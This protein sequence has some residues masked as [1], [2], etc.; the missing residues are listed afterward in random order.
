MVERTL[1][2]TFALRK[3]Y[4]YGTQFK[5]LE[6]RAHAKRV[7]D[8]DEDL[9]ESAGRILGS[10]EDMRMNLDYSH[11]EGAAI[12]L[13]ESSRAMA[14]VEAESSRLQALYPYVAEMKDEL[15][16][17]ASKA[18]R[19]LNAGFADPLTG[20]VLEPRNPLVAGQ[21]YDLLIDVGP[22]WSKV[23]SLVIGNEI[24]PEAALPPDEDGYAIHVVFIS[25]DTEPK[26]FS[27]WIWI[28]RR[29]GRS[30]PYNFISK[31]KAT[32]CG[33]IAFR[34]KAPALAG[35][36]DTTQLHGRLCLYYENNL[37][38]SAR[39]QA[40]VAR[41][42]DVRLE[43]DNVVDVDYVLSGTVQNLERLATRTL[44]FSSK[45]QPREHPIALNLTLNDD[46]KAHRILVRELDE[47][48]T[49]AP[50]SDSPVGW[51]PFD[52]SAA[53]DALNKAREDLKSCFYERDNNGNVVKDQSGEPKIWVNKNGRGK[54]R[55]Q[56]KWD[57]LILAELGSSLFN[58]AF[59]N[60]IPEGKWAT[61]AKWMRALQ[62][63]LERKSIIQVARTGPANYVFP[64]GLVY[65]YPLWGARKDYKFCRVINAEWAEDGLR[66]KEP[67]DACPYRNEDYH[68]KDVICPYGF[69]GLNHIIEQPVSALRQLPDGSYVHQDATDK[70]IMLGDNLDL[71]VV[72]THDVAK[73]DLDSHLMRLGLIKPMRINPPNPADDTDKVR[74]MLQGATVVYFLC[75]GEYDLARTEPFLSIGLRDGGETHRIYPQTL[76]SWA[77]TPDVLESWETQHPL[78]FINGCHTANLTP[79]EVLNFVTAF[80]LAGAGGIIGTE[81]SVLAPVAMEISEMVFAKMMKEDQQKQKTTVGQ[82]MYQTR[83]ELANK[84]NLLG[85]AYTLYC[86]ANLHISKN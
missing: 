75:H 53:R 44:S 50:S 38:Q 35:E 57:L 6:S 37:L 80:G 76:Q 17:L 82:A 27:N 21:E 26:L 55:D 60:V 58:K 10:M 23:K 5:A 7:F 48:S 3:P 40:T 67:D 72:V 24:F 12:P 71:S 47:L 70:L 69:W 2:S 49:A 85:L 34:I 33:P 46:G 79:G 36:S 54:T 61:N 22:K 16:D 78:I 30:F 43:V 81:V 29:T 83:W 63:R 52:P 62:K 56:F 18:P 59:G 4:L 66:Q 74:T 77:R 41:T 8:L 9:K 31:T 15:D 73:A 68:A 64:W 86:L 11:E 51:T 25:D 13:G 20:K 1:R 84:G 28:P 65:Q 45:E 14:T 39:V 42:P 32:T 19:A